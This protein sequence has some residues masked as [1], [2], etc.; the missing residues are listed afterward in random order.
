MLWS[1]HHMDPLYSTGWLCTGRRTLD[2]KINIKGWSRVSPWVLQQD[3]WLLR[4]PQEMVNLNRLSKHMFTGSYAI[5]RCM[6][7]KDIFGTS[8]NAYSRRFGFLDLWEIGLY[9]YSLENPIIPITDRSI[10][11]NAR[12]NS[13]VTELSATVW[14]RLCSQLLA[15][16]GYAI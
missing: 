3:L 2:V 11:Q 1:Y 5:M 9:R 16:I 4:F 14:F 6:R 13:L 10:D 15:L 7:V 8:P 12:G